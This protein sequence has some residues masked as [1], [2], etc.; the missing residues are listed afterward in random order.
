MEELIEKSK[1]KSTKSHDYDLRE[2]MIETKKAEKVEDGRKQLELISDV[3]KKIELLGKRIRQRLIIKWVIVMM[4]FGLGII[5]A[6]F[7]IIGA[8]KYLLA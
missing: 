2:I 1:M 5:F 7:V 6:E 8:I 3:E 4:G